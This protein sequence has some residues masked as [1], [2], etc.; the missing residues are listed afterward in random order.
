[1]NRA[2][3]AHHVR[4]GSVVPMP[5]GNMHPRVE[6][7]SSHNPLQIVEKEFDTLRDFVDNPLKNIRNVNYDDIDEKA[8]WSA[9]A[10]EMVL[11]R[12][13]IFNL[14]KNLSP[15]LQCHDKVNSFEIKIGEVLSAL[16]PDYLALDIVSSRFLF[17][18]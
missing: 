4:L 9:P 12:D 16:N 5:S 1:L 10:F 2:L 17:E 18:K 14:H 8:R 3:P 6:L 11:T 7:F 13:R 15:V